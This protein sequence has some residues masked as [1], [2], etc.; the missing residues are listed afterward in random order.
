MKIVFFVKSFPKTSET[1]IV[2]QVEQLKASVFCQIKGDY[3][4]KNHNKRS[5]HYFGDIPFLLKLKRKFYSLFN[6]YFDPIS[7]R[8]KK[9]VEGKLLKGKYDVALI[10]YGSNAIKFGEAC[11]NAKVPYVIHFHGYDVSALLK[12]NLYKELLQKSILDSKSLIVVNSF[13]KRMLINKFNIS[14]DKINIIP[15]GVNVEVF[16]RISQ[17]NNKCVFIM[18]G[19]LTPKKGPLLTLKAFELCAAKFDNVELVI[20]GDGPLKNELLEN[21][22]S[23]NFTNKITYLGKQN[24]LEVKEKLNSSDVFLQH[25]VTAENGDQEGWPISIAEA[26]AMGLPIISTLHSGIQDQVIQGKNG[27]LVKEYDYIGMGEYMYK[28]AV[29]KDLRKT[30]GKASRIFIEKNGC[31]FKQISKLESVLSE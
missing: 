11:K 10:Q 8:Q 1:F 12:I 5:I 30:M 15:C 13:Q 27:F 19:R 17:Y 16:K 20:I 26:C 6:L 3:E 22:K 14:E 31:L 21:I 9:L 23:S 4:L 7:N 24:S 28:L 18:I 25:S 2:N 29:S